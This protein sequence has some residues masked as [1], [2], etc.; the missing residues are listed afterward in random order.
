MISV[1]YKE[2][3]QFVRRNL[4]K[5]GCTIRPRKRAYLPKLQRNLQKYARNL[6]LRIRIRTDNDESRRSLCGDQSTI[7]LYRIQLMGVINRVIDKTK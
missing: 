1:R 3:R 7:Y 4:N 5:I 2:D 6:R